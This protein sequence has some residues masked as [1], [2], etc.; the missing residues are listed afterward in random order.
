ML[1]PTSIVVINFD[2]FFVSIESKDPQ[3]DLE[4]TMELLKSIGGTNIEEV[5]E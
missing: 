1:L 4:E 2:G 3:F 5:L